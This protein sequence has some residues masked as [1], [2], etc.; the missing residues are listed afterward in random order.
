MADKVISLEVDV[1]VGGEE[2]INSLERKIKKIEAQL[3]TSKGEGF[4]QLNKELEITKIKLNAVNASATKARGALNQI[5]SSTTTFKTGVSGASRAMGTFANGARKSK[6]LITELSSNLLGAT[7][8]WGLVALAAIA[9]GKAIYDYAQQLSFA[10]EEEIKLAKVQEARIEI[11]KR[12]NE[13]IGEEVGALRVLTER[14][15]DTNF[16]SAERKEIIDKIHKDHHVTIQDLKDEKKFADEVSKSYEGIIKQLKMRINLEVR[17]EEYAN[18]VKDEIALLDSLPRLQAAADKSM[19]KLLGGASS[20]M[21]D[22]VEL[23]GAGTKAALELDEAQDNITK[24]LREQNDIL[25][26]IKILEEDAPPP[27]SSTDREKKSAL[28]KAAADAE[29]ALREKLAKE[30][31]LIGKNKFDREMVLAMN[32]FEELTKN[33]DDN[34]QIVIDA[35]LI[36]NEK[37]R[38]IDAAEKIFNDAEEKKKQESIEAIRE[39]YRQKAK[40]EK[41][42]TDLEKLDLEEQ[43]VIAELDKFDATE[44]QKEEVRNFYLQKRKTLEVKTEEEIA[45]A[46]SKINALALDSA[47]GLL[48]EGFDTETKL[49]KAAFNAGKALS[50]ARAG[51]NTYAAANAALKTGSEINPAYGLISAGIAI[52]TGLLNVKK[53]LSTKVGSTSGGGGSPTQTSQSSSNIQPQQTGFTDLR[54]QRIQVDPIKV[55]VSESDISNAMLSANQ[56][57]QVS[58]IK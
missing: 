3:R 47:I 21:I 54:N 56:T 53:I 36:L 2:S 29:I 16:Q 4:K 50:I 20:E 15:K 49:G 39:K 52:T 42:V 43:R 57:K 18:L 33:L 30:V 1:S 58:V 28:D 25:A 5:N 51:I 26:K 14:L 45:E 27:Q 37:I 6:E 44:K 23:Y 7:S 31:F 8:V 35:K 12:A 34:N 46:K 19:G 41:A 10:E 17:R 13:K 32:E 40:D 38:Q 11:S 22:Q 48:Q 24:N 9:V 55:W